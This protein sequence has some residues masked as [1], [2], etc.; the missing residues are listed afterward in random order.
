MGRP[1][2]PHLIRRCFKVHR[3]LWDLFTS[4]CKDREVTYSETI[5]DLIRKWIAEPYQPEK[6]K[7]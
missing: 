2:K 7:K 5:E 6:E 3:G 1:L 4:E